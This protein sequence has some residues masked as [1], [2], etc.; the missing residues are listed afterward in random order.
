VLTVPSRAPPREIVSQ[1]FTLRK[2]DEDV[3]ATLVAQVFK[4]AKAEGK[5]IWYFTTPKSV[6]IEVIQKHAIPLDKVHAGKAIF[7]HKGA[8]YTGHFEEPINH[9][10]KVLIPGKDGSKYETSMSL[11][12]EP[13]FLRTDTRLVNQS[14][15]R[16]LHI[17]RVTRFGD[18]GES[19]PAPP[20]TSSALVKGPRPQPKGLKARYQPFGVT[21]K[22]GADSDSDGDVEMAQ[23][24]PLLNGS[25]DAKSDSPKK[26]A[27]KRKHG[28][29]EKEAPNHEEPAST[30]AKKP[31]KA[32]VDS[33]PA[34][35]SPAKPVKQTPIAPPPVP[36]SSAKT[37]APS[38][39]VQP[40]P[41]KKSKSKDKS[42]KKDSASTEKASESKKPAK[43][44]PVLPPAVPTAKSS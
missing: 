35:S 42:K 31:K 36:P 39:P 13:I 28:D 17:T 44:T 15:D 29:V 16:V 20:S 2:A 4:K 30:P 24:P 11:P 10:I 8:E 9:A 34:E 3:D 12:E 5:Q 26:A 18:E 40:S 38:E 27:K 23:A 1:G 21:G 33:K 14:V 43:V 41:V 25:A 22:P 19:E 37:A 6:P 32:R 7:A